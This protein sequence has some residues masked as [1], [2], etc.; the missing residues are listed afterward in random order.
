[1]QKYTKELL[2]DL[3]PKSCSVRDL[4]LKLGMT[5]I[6]RQ[7]ERIIEKLLEK[8]EIDTSHWPMPKENYWIKLQKS[9]GTLA[10]QHTQHN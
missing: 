9:K 2:A 1:M 3:V 7:K 4:M 6:Y 5:S 8:Y 10:R